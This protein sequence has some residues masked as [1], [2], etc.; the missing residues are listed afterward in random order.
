MKTKLLFISMML[1]AIL[2]TSC[3]KSEVDVTLDDYDM[4]FTYYD[5]DFDFSTYQTFVVRDSV[6][7]ISDYLTEKE[8]REFYT[9]GTSDKIRAKIS[10]ELTALG[11]T[12]TADE[13]NADFLMNPT[14][15]LMEK[16]D[17]YYYPGW[18]WGY[19]G[20]WGWYY[21]S[22][23]YYYPY[24]PSYGYS[25][26]YTYETGALIMEILNG[27]SVRA[28]LEWLEENG[29]EADPSNAP[30]VELNWTG[31]IEGIAGN[32]ASYNESRA[33]Q[34]IEEAFEQSPYLK[35]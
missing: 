2:F 5:T 24:Y 11:Y 29:P 30:Q 25:Y 34:G 18:W 9:N 12:E 4:T 19:G 14:V 13:D 1:V 6:L 22:T 7:L 23:D 28:Y 15:T 32:T 35:K 31:H 26:S 17:Y 20:Y 10:S 3:Y 21:K 8:K 27:D 16:T 33:K